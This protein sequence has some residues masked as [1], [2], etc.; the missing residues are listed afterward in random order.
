LADV[1]Q[2]CEAMQCEIQMV[3]LIGQVTVSR[4]VRK[5]GGG[6]GYEDP[7]IAKIYQEGPHCLHMQNLRQLYHAITVGPI[8]LQFSALVFD[9]LLSLRY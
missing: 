6:G 7:P 8:S 1:P 4:P 3:R 5:G 2:Q 9:S